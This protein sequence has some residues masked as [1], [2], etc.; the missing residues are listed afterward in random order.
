MSSEPEV[1]PNLL[2]DLTGE[3]VDEI[4]RAVDEAASAVTPQDL[5]RL[6]NRLAHARSTGGSARVVARAVIE[7]ALAHV[8]GLR[9]GRVS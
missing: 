5:R 3:R 1:P 7:W 8:P 6:E 2:Q 4:I 9:I